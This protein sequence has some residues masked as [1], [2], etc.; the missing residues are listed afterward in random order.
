MALS[1]LDGLIISQIIFI[2]AYFAILRHL[3]SLRHIRYAFLIIMTIQCQVALAYGTVMGGHAFM[4]KRAGG[5]KKVTTLN[6]CHM[7]LLNILLIICWSFIMVDVE[8]GSAWV[9]L[10]GN[11]TVVFLVLLVSI[12]VITL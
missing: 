6:L 9:I 7:L 8:L 12:L 4:L 2:L 10:G 1:R 3:G 11:C 5:I